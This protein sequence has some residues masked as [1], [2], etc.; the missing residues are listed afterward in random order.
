[1]YKITYNKNVPENGMG[2]NE[3]KIGKTAYPLKE[4]SY[5]LIPEAG[6]GK[7][8][9]GLKKAGNYSISNMKIE[10]LDKG[11][12]EL[13]GIV[14]SVQEEPAWE[15]DN[16]NWTNMDIP[17]GIYE[18]EFTAEQTR[19]YWQVIAIK[20]QWEP[21]FLGASVPADGNEVK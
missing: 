5:V 10:K 7:I 2:W 3:L 17:G 20:G 19:A 18:Y 6:K 11:L 9:F 15:I 4:E 12:L 1:M 8:E 21:R 16:V 14:G 13:G